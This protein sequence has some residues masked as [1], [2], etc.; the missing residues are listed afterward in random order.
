MRDF[1]SSKMV[2][3]INCSL[4]SLSEKAQHQRLNKKVLQAMMSLNTLPTTQ[5]ANTLVIIKPKDKMVN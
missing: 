2:L 1:D 5:R 3:E 4:L